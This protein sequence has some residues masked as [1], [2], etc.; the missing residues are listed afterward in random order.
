MK[1]AS[2][3][4]GGAVWATAGG[5]GTASILER[6][7]QMATITGSFE[8]GKQFE[9]VLA[10]L[11]I[12]ATTV[13]R[14]GQ[15]V[16]GPDSPSRSIH[17]LVSGRM[18]ISQRAD[19]GSEVLLEIVL[20]EE[21]FGES[22]FLPPARVCEQARAVVDATVMAWAVSDIEHL[23]M[24]RP[25]LAVALLQI[26]SKRNAELVRRIESFSIDTIVQRLARSLIRLSERLG[27]PEGDGC[28]R[29]MPLTHTLLSRYVG[30]SREI[31]TQHMNRL[32]RRGLVNYSRT[33]ISFHC[34]T[35][36]TVFDGTACE[37]SAQV[38]D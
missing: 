4:S 7:G 17:L 11:P 38:N 5:Q 19:D 25:G 15:V 1:M 22:A 13:Y 35:L 18:E 32:R 14:K 20:P 26:V 30:T 34:N 8:P 21:L 27:S 33:G 24:R 10:H 3:E 28:V 12:S 31:V 16:Y 9:D 6:K 2:N 29:M 37:V 23:V 36:R